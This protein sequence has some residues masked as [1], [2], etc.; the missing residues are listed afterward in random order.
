MVLDPEKDVKL[1]A[2]VGVVVALQRSS[3]AGPTAPPSTYVL[4][5]QLVVVTSEA[6]F[7]AEVQRRSAVTLHALVAEHGAAGSR[8]PTVLDVCAAGVWR[9]LAGGGVAVDRLAVNLRC[10]LSLQR[11]RVPV[12]GVA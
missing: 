8:P 9:F 3:S 6:V 12:K 5:A 1:R 11:I 7:V 2:G 4:F 10:P